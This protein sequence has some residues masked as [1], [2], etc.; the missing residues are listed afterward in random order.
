MNGRKVH[1][2]KACPKHQYVFVECGPFEV[3]VLILPNWQNTKLII[4]TG[5]NIKHNSFQCQAK[6]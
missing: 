4:E 5:N 6:F 1:K 2:Q 3:P